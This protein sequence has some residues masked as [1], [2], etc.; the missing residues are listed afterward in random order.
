MHPLYSA[1]IFFLIY[2]TVTALSLPGGASIMTV[3]GG[4]IFGL[5][6]G[7]L[8]SSFA[9]TIG[10]TAAFLVARFLFREK[11]QEKFADKLATINKGIE[12]E[13]AFY[14]FTLRLVPA[15]PFF[16]I[17]IAMGLTSMKTLTFFLTSQIGML[18]GTIIYV[19][20]GTQLAQIKSM[21]DIISGKLL[22]ACILLGLFPLLAKKTIELIQYYREKNLAQKKQKI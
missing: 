1:I 12:K 22:F 4:M 6:I 8:L 10:A 15:F 5:Y 20:A 19:Y 21:Q 16:M 18:A 2:V 14:L 11:L 13:G 17:N 9:S 7:T 3:S